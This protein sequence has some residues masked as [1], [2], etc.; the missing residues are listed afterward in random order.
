MIKIRRK[1]MM[2]FLITLLLGGFLLY[3]KEHIYQLMIIPIIVG[4]LFSLVKDVKIHNMKISLF[5]IGLS[6]S[7][8]IVDKIY[9]I[10]LSNWGINYVTFLWIWTIFIALKRQYLL[11]SMLEK[12]YPY[13]K[14]KYNR[15]STISERKGRIPG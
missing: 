7:L 8:I 14:M 4:M 6:A 3:T 5:I 13:V 9:D 2:Y 1:S 15:Y 11:F 12:F 10:N